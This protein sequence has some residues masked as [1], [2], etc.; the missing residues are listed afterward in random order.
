MPAIIRKEKRTELKQ[1][2]CEYLK[3]DDGMKGTAWYLEKVRDLFQSFNT[4][5]GI[6]SLLTLVLEKYLYPG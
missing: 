1:S 6:D 5:T 4:S 3:G 2:K